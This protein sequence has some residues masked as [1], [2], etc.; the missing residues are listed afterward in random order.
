MI[1]IENLDIRIYEDRKQLGESAATLVAD[2]LNELLTSKPFINVIFAAAPSQNEFLSALIQKDIDWSKINA[3]HMDEYIGLS[4]DAPQGFGN[5]LKERIFDKVAFNAVYYLNGNATDIAAECNRYADLLMKHPVDITCMGIGENGHLA[6]NDP[7]VANFYD[8]EL[9]KVVELD[10]ECRQQQ[11]NDGCFKNLDL[12]PVKAL[13]LTIP[14][15]LN[16]DYIYCM[17]PGST[18]S[19]AVYNTLNKD[20][21][22]KYP[23][24]I[25]R[26]HPAAILFL[27]KQSSALI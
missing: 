24:T 26:K 15:L 4:P 16:A 9:V 20:I 6:F 11:V 2:K 27:D 10:Q 5:F 14:A 19:K 22:E 23:S 8:T 17:V 25:L 7:P 3:F 1:K 21:Q 13:T 12:V 18:K